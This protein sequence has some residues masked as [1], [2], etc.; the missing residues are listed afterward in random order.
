MLWSDKA[1]HTSYKYVLNVVTVLHNR[2]SACISTGQL[3]EQPIRARSRYDLNK[4]QHH[5]CFSAG[6][7]ADMPA[8]I[9]NKN[10]RQI[11]RDAGPASRMP[12]HIATI[13]RSL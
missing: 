3:Q 1:G 8:H 6:I 13:E 10:I 9:P 5:R 7:A 11:R 12:G 2:G 4:D